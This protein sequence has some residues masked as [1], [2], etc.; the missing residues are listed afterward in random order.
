MYARCD[1]ADQRLCKQAFSP[2]VY[3]EEDD[4]PRVENA[5]PF[6]MLLYPEVNANALT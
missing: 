4:E 5:R 6:E 1:D 3:I 2:K